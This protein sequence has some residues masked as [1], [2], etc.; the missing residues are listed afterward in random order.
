MAEQEAAIDARPV[1]GWQAWLIRH[2]NLLLF[3]AAAL[4]FAGFVALF[5]WTQS[6]P[7]KPVYAGL[8]EKE[9][10]A[11]VEALEKAH[12]PYRVEAGAVLVPA[13]QVASV[14]IRLAGEG[15]APKGG[16]GFELFDR[17]ELFGLSE[18]AQRVNL[19]RALQGELAR[20]IEAIPQV[21]AARVHLVLPKESPFAG[22]ERKASAS[23]ML[24][25]S[26]EL[27]RRAVVAIQN[28]V[29]ASVPRLAPEDVVIVDASGRLLS[30]ERGDQLARGETIEEFQ[31]RLEQR[32][33]RRLE[34]MLAQL[35]GPGRAVARVWVELDR[36]Y[37]EERRTRFDPDEQV[38]RERRTL[39]ESRASSEA[40]PLGVPGVASNTPGANPAQQG[41]SQGSRASRREE[42]LRYEISSV[43]QR[44][45]VPAGAI[46]RISVAVAVAGNEKDGKF[47]P[48]PASELGK[49]EALVKRAVGFDEERGDRVVVESMPLVDLRSQQDEAAL[50]MAERRAFYLRLARYLAA[51]LLIAMIGWFVLRP[52]GM[53]LRAASS[54]A[55]SSSASDALPSETPPALS[56]EAYQR[57]ASMELAR[58]AIEMDPE[59]ARRVLREWVEG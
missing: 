33:E 5:A 54:T 41:A 51:L 4:A 57:L 46:R 6:P 14:R 27:P 11:V 8:S 1:Q 21:A 18:F 16:I 49:I 2:R 50:E 15:I 36:S 29:A 47:E 35:V 12:V 23:V 17:K 19:Q 25:L 58:R 3:A 43:E 26:G 32:I 22:R 38:V 53:R 48:L 7:W 34:S 28:L 10:A 56:S 13:D 30:G 40:L 59:R 45:I 42:E 55:P 37:L 52:L 20:T 44:R 39:E 24:K 9:A 31:A